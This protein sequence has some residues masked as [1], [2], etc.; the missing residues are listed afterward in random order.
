MRRTDQQPPENRSRA[1]ATA[2]P[3]TAP[4][5]W[6]RRLASRQSDQPADLDGVA[7]LGYN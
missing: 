7:V 2:L 4:T 5:C 6:I 1:M 3:K